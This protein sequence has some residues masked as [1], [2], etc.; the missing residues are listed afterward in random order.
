MEGGFLGLGVRSRAGSPPR[1]LLP[2]AAILSSPRQLQHHFGYHSRG[3]CPLTAPGRRRCLCPL[4]PGYPAKLPE[5]RG[6]FASSSR[7]QPPGPSN[8][9]GDRLFPLRDSRYGLQLRLVFI[10]ALP[11]T[12]FLPRPLTRSQPQRHC[13]GREPVCGA[14]TRRDGRDRRR[15]PAGPATPARRTCLP[16]ASTARQP[17]WGSEEGAGRWEPVGA[18]PGWGREARGGPLPSSHLP[19]RGSAD[20]RGIPSAPRRSAGCPRRTLSPP[21]RVCWQGRSG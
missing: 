7:C 10:P 19:N 15:S 13:P 16:G 12:P 4:P 18:A 8:P 9:R 17:V 11:A 21:R 6:H 1:L 2:A 14:G 5:L 20:P 3:A